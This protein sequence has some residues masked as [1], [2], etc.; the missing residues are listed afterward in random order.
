[1]LSNHIISRV[2]LF[3]FL[4]MVGFAL[5]MGF[6]YRSFLGIF[7]ALIAL[8]AGI[9]FIHLMTKAKRE[10]LQAKELLNRSEV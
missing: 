6:Y 9:Y 2:I 4:A 10:Y 3:A 8:G 1:M 7:L 5:A